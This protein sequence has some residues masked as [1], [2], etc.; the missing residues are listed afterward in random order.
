MAKRNAANVGCTVGNDK[1]H[2]FGWP[3]H[4][5][6]A[7]HWP[8]EMLLPEGSCSLSDDRTIDECGFFRGKA[9]KNCTERC[10]EPCIAISSAYRYGVYRAISMPKLEGPFTGVLRGKGDGTLQKRKATLG[11]LHN[12]GYMGDSVYRYGTGGGGGIAGIKTCSE[13]MRSDLRRNG[14][15]RHIG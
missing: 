11:W 8:P 6:M 15:F 14:V 7:S 5:L 10:S 12:Y 4:F 3:Y 13:G 1:S 2:Q 9:F